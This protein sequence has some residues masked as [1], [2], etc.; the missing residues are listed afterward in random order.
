MGTSTSYSGPTGYNPLLPDW[1]QEPDDDQEESENQTDDITPEVDWGQPKR[2]LSNYLND[3]DPTYLRRSISNFVKAGGGAKGSTKSSLPGRNTLRGLGN[4]LSSASSD[5]K[6]TFRELGIDFTGKDSTE[7]VSQLV[8]SICRST[9]T[10]EEAIARDAAVDVLYDV[11]EHL[12]DS[13]ND[14]D[15][16]DSLDENTISDIIVKYVSTYVYKKFMQLLAQRV[17]K[18]EV[19]SSEVIEIEWEIKTLIQAKAQGV[20]IS[21][22]INEIDWKGNE[23][24]QIT[25]NIFNDVYQILEGLE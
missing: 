18:N 7:I 1:A 10:R 23:G 24:I 21:K 4:F 2:N 9:N 8:D 11:F 17:E 20:F 13:E 12:D 25:N 15:S 6:E 16:I 3:R 19:S 14:L 22:N 5:F